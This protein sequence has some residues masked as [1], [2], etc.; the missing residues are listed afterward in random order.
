M[1]RVIYV[2]P[3]GRRVRPP[4][5][6]KPGSVGSKAGPLIGIVAGLALASQAV[7]HGHLPLPHT[8]AGQAPAAIAAALPGG[9]GYTQASWAAALL[10]AGGWRSTGCNLGAVEAWETAEGGN[11]ANNAAFNPLNTT[12]TEPGSRAVNVVGPGQ[13][14]QAYTSWRQGFAATITTLGNG[15]YGAI[16]SALAAGNDA[17]AVAGAIAASPWGTKPFQ[18][19]CA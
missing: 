18:A 12:Q 10:K 6:A 15:H 14:V 7:G 11:W 5:G 8:A 13:G 1:A 17:Q 4:R 19:S 3:R 2:D 9:S 16:L